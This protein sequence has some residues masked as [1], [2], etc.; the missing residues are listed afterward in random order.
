VANA[1][2]RSGA[3]VVHGDAHEFLRN[4]KLDAR[5]FFDGQKPPFR[6]N[7]F[8]AAVGGPVKHD[9]AFFFVNYE[10]L[11]QALTRTSIATVPSVAARAGNLP[12]GKVTL[13]PAVV[14][15]LALWPLPNGPLL[16]NGYT[17]EYIFTAKSPAAEN[18]GLVKVDHS[19]SPKDSL[20]FSWSTD[21]GHTQTPNALNSFFADNRLGLEKAPVLRNN[22]G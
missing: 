9:K 20:T 1:V 19:L 2:S 7:Q 8:G 22:P 5:N 16:G 18:T 11:Q 6:R 17:A 4:D 15:Y 13:S 21:N 12:E 14:P 3:N 10:G